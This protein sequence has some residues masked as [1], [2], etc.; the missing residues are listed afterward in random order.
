MTRRAIAAIGIVLGAA[1]LLAALPDAA[2]ALTDAE[3]CKQ[4]RICK[5]ITPP[6]SQNPKPNRP[7]QAPYTQCTWVKKCPGD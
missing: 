3:I 6:C 4:V 5:T 1:A 7:C 2:Y